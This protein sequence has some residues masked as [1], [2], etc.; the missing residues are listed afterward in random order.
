MSPSIVCGISLIIM[1]SLFTYIVM[2]WEKSVTPLK[3]APTSSLERK[4]I[5]AP[6]T[7]PTTPV[8]NDEPIIEEETW[9]QVK[10][11]ADEMA[12]ERE[13]TT[14]ANKDMVHFTQA[15]WHDEH[16][17]KALEAI[18]DGDNQRA[19]ELLS[20][21][22]TKFPASIEA[23]ENLAALYFSHGELASAFEILDDGLKLQPHNLR[24]IILKSRL[25]VEQGHQREALT[26]L[27]PFNPDINTT[28][29]YYAILAAIFESLGRTTE[30]GSIYQTLIKLD[31]ANGQYWLG[32]GIAFENKHSNQQAIEAYQRASQS[33]TSQPSVRSYAEN[34]LKTL[35]G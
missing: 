35:Q 15:D 16:I 26:L 22:L 3:T 5:M 14:S 13:D 27:E 2:T 34:R 17:N 23:R 32:L 4:S 24:L 10:N 29:E 7:M 12:I 25:L 1:F 20:T 11:N 18:Q 21:I 8:L 28:P 19:I 33:D 31:P 9:E 30:A 6:V